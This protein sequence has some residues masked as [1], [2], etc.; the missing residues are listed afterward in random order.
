MVSRHFLPRTWVDNPMMFSKLPPDLFC[1][2]LS[3]FLFL[4]KS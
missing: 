1:P 2:S 4:E 3:S